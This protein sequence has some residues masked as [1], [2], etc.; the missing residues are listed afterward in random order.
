MKR[1]IVKGKTVKPKGDNGFF[2]RFLVLSA[3][4]LVMGFYALNKIFS[5]PSSKYNQAYDLVDLDINQI[6]ANDLYDGTPVVTLV[7]E[8][9][10]ITTPPATVEITSSIS[11]IPI[12]YTLDGSTPNADSFLYTT[13]LV[14]EDVIPY[15][16]RAIG[17]VGDRYTDVSNLSFVIVPPLVA[18]GIYPV[19]GSYSTPLV[20]TLQNKGAGGESSEVYYTLDGSSP[21]D[22]DSRIKYQ[23]PFT[24]SKSGE[25]VV[26]AVSQMEGVVPSKI[27][28]AEYTLL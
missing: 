12:Y 3:V 20:V 7:G 26:K 14:L 21:V 2:F 25:V 16:I 24:L 28:S 17:M 23:K 18:P 4:F 19:S 22:S 27:S 5:S 8:N 9:D 10:S 1:K 15:T 13:P 11:G 6:T